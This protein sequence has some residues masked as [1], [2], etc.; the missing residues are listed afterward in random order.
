MQRRAAPV[1]KPLRQN[2]IHQRGD[3]LSTIV[4]YCGDDEGA[5]KTA[6]HL[7]RGVGFNPVD[8]GSLSA[9]RYLKPFSLLVA[10]LALQW[11]GRP[12]ISLSFERFPK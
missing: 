3:R 7:I 10:Q 6:A 9:A 2:G 1:G 12:A 8:L 4:V 11:L 5:K